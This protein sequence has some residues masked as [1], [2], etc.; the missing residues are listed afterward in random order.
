VTY[1]TPAAGRLG[2]RGCADP[3]WVGD[4]GGVAQQ[5][6]TFAKL[7][8]ERDKKEKAVA[9]ADRRAQQA[10]S[11]A[12][13]PTVKLDPDNEANILARLAELHAAFESGSV[14]I[15]EFEDR[16]DQLRTKLQIG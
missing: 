14:S 1:A 10:A 16:R 15:D 5:R 13:P 11:V 3:G 2:R 4:T 8:R 7:Q 9:K 6:S 12:E